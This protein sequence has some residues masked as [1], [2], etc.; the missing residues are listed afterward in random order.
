MQISLQ[1]SFEQ[2]DLP[3]GASNLGQLLRLENGNIKKLH[4]KK[5]LYTASRQLKP[6]EKQETAV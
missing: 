4:L 5:Y 2:I 1:K 3:L 6:K